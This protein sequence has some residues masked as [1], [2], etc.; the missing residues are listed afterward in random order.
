MK[1]FYYAER[2][3]CSAYIQEN[4]GWGWS[5]N[6]GIPPKPGFRSIT[7]S[8]RKYRKRTKTKKM[9]KLKK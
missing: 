8:F 7:L 3:G 6:K 2:K 5:I 1:F 9:A 4:D